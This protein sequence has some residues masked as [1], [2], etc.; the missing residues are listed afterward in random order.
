MV[1]G[2]HESAQTPHTYRVNDAI[3]EGS[4]AV[5]YAGDLFRDFAGGRIIGARYEAA[6]AQAAKPGFLSFCVLLRPYDDRV[7]RISR[8]APRYDCLG[9]FAV[10]QT[11][12]TRTAGGNVGALSRRHPGNSYSMGRSLDESVEQRTSIVYPAEA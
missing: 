8:I 2:G 9:D 7:Q 6:L 5:L 11:L 12:Q 10:T 1:A 4:D 3:T